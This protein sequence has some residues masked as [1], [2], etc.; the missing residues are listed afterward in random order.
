VKPPILRQTARAARAAYRRLAA[1]EGVVLI[2]ALI[3]M[4][5]LTV[6]TAAA[7]ELV[8]TNETSFGKDN[9]SNSAL[10]IAEAG[11]AAAMNAIEAIPVA[12]DN[13]ASLSGHGSLENGTWSYTATRVQS[14][15]D[16]TKYTWTIDS[17][18]TLGDQKHVVED[19]LGQTI[20]ATSQ[21]VTTATPASAAYGYGM[22][23]G[24]ASSDCT[25]NSSPNPNQFSGSGTASVN[26][27]TAG[28]LCFSGGSNIQE[29]STSSGNTVTVYVGGR[30]ASKSE[31]QFVG[32][33]S[34]YV[35][36]VTAVGG[37]YDQ[38]H[39][40]AVSCSKLGSPVQNVNGASYGSGVYAN[41]YSSTQ[42][43]VAKPTIDTNWYSNAE[44]GPSHACNGSSTYPNDNQTGSQPWSS[45]K[46]SQKVLDSDSTRN[47]SISS[48]DPLQLV[49]NW[50][51]LMNSFDCR[52][53]DAG[54]NLV[55][56]L[57]WTYPSG[58]M[59]SSNPGTLVISGTVFIDGN[60]TFGS[61][62]YALYQG[63]GTIYVNG[64]ISFGNGAKVCAQPISGSACVG[65][66]NPS[67][68]LL[69]L[70]AVNAQNASSGWTMSG[71]GTYEG[72]AFLNGV[73]NA[74]N[75]AQMNGPVIA[76]TALM[77]GAMNLRSTFNP[78]SGAPGAASTSTSTTNGP[79]QVT[80][81]PISG[82]W[83]QL[84]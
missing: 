46:F 31:T 67:Q 51:Q 60:L 52:F 73:F 43:T 84:G 25:N 79:D 41:V 34:K 20:V 6:S 27:Y 76:D 15:T 53:Y 39:S 55:G 26:V 1:S 36:S 65:N 75:G 37:C 32:T 77:S 81:T 7:I 56:R 45:A 78:P 44:P 70:V 57:A 83:R 42:N 64:T 38:N 30:L 10:D 19:T 5:V 61:S 8:Q 16:S 33:T 35:K 50:N 12:Q 71:A 23:L 18:G 49:N 17:T 80:Y 13:T 47:T 3:V 29:P 68:N 4:F 66:F 24:A 48:V 2:W 14:T 28:S 11:L 62:D 74:G 58:G 22:F 69:E 63:V 40:A 9:R 72:I 59:S 54:G 82:G 21:T